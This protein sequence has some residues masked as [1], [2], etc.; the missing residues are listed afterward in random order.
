MAEQFATIE[1]YIG[2]FPDDVQIVLQE[3]RRRIRSVVPE[4][5]ETI[6]YQIPTM[7][8]D[9]RSLVHF[10]AWKHHVSLYPVPGA[11]EAFQQELAPYLAGKGSVRLSLHKPIPNGLIERLVTLLAQQRHGHAG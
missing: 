2:S 4:A 7:T 3:V 10:A 9:G 8:L 11:D 5:G 1:E 6:R